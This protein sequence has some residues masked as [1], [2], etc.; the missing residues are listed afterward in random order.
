MTGDFA[1]RLSAIERA[2]GTNLCLWLRPT[3]REMPLAIQ[4][5]DDPF[6]PFS[7]TVIAATHD[8]VCA[9]MF[10][11]ASY[12]ALGAAGTVALERSIAHA[13]AEHDALTILHGPFYGP[14]YA[15]ASAPLAFNA[16]A[17]TIVRAEDAPAYHSVGVHAFVTGADTPGTISRFDGSTLLIADWNGAGQTT[18][19]V[20]A[21]DALGRGY[22]ED[23]AEK[24]RAALEALR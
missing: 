1:E 16:D 17:V 19:R 6:L 8:I 4:K 14:D 3:L 2:T 10:D 15:Q 23:F 7:R 13:A 24:A 5:Y 22:D 20:I 21:E 18:L 12:M 9:F 11:L